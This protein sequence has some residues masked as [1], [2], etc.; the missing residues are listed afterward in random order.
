MNRRVRHLPIAL[1]FSLALLPAIVLLLFGLV[2]A[3]AFSTP[4]AGALECRGDCCTLAIDPWLAGNGIQRAKLGC[5]L[6]G[7]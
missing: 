3:A 2:I 1:K 6:G 5:S 4:C 7:Q